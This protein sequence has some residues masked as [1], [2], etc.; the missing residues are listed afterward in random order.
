VTERTAAPARVLVAD[1]EPAITTLMA[2]MLAYAGFGVLRAHGGAEALTLARTERPDVILLDVMMP[3]LDGRDTCRAL[4]M[5]LA[6]RH[7]PVVLFSSADERDVHWRGA[8]ADAFLQKPFSIRALPDFIHSV[9][10]GGSS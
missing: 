8:G 2:D 5:D 10:G 6:L 9:L 4:K 3:D 7:I 1:D